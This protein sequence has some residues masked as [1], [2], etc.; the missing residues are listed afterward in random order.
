MCIGYALDRKSA[1]AEFW[2]GLRS[3]CAAAAAGS[4]GH[5]EP[6][7]F[8]I[9]PTMSGSRRRA[10]RTRRPDLLRAVG[11][12]VLGLRVHS[13]MTPS[14]PA[15]TSEPPRERKDEIAAFAACDGST[16]TGRCVPLQHRHR[17]EV[18]RVPG[19][20]LERLHPPLAED[21]PSLPSSTTYS[22]AIR[23]SST[24]PPGGASAAPASARASSARRRSCAC[25]GR[26][27]GYV[28]IARPAPRRRVEE[29]GDDREPVSSRASARISAFFPSPGTRTARSAARPPPRRI[30][31]ARRGDGSSPS[32]ARRSRV[33]TVHGP[34]MSPRPSPMRRR[35]VSR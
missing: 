31:R 16:S 20:A 12:R 14:G 5:L 34:A 9:S 1:R 3:L 28:A 13:T 21:D 23:N 19:R 29:L 10:G 18:E 6:T 7:V 30:V 32:R 4:A 35:G 26:R 17:R 27:S 15:A 11:E 22:A 24:S 2:F 25:C 8:P 33:S